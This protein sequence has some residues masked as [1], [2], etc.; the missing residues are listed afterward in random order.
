MTDRGTIHQVA[1]G[2]YMLELPANGVAILYEDGKQLPGGVGY[3]DALVQFAGEVIRL[4][5]MIDTIRRDPEI[6]DP[7]DPHKRRDI[8]AELDRWLVSRASFREATVSHV[9][10]RAARDEIEAL[11]QLQLANVEENKWL[12]D[13]DE[14]VFLKAI[15][16]A[17]TKTRTQAL[18]EAEIAC[19][20]EARDY[21]IS[22]GQDNYRDGC[23]N[24]ASTIRA[25][26]EKR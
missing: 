3:L 25:L 26:K 24:C 8:V 10:L 5:S 12:R 6:T 11:R 7:R 19:L 13:N 17:C 1:A 18:E 2:P 23:R 9:L 21:V 15:D 4:R 14:R 20:T 16:V 22:L